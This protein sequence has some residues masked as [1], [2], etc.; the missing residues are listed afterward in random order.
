MKKPADKNN[1]TFTS[2]MDCTIYRFERKKSCST[3][4]SQARSLNVFTVW[5][6]R[7]GLVRKAPPR[8]RHYINRPLAV[9]RADFK[10]W[11]HHKLDLS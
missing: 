9:L 2:I 10:Y 11:Q 8:L 3:S 5:V 4:Q 1:S 6:C 7:T